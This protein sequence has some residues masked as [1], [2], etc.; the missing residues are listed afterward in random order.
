VHRIRDSILH[1]RNGYIFELGGKSFFAFGG[2]RSH[3]IS[4]GILDE[5]DYPSR[6]R[7]ME[8]RRRWT[9]RQ[10]LFRVNHESWWQEEMPSAEEM[11]FGLATLQAHGNRVDYIVSHCCPQGISDVLSG[12]FY[13]PDA[14]TEYFE[15]LSQTV[16]FDY[17]F[18][19]HYHENR[20][21]FRKYI[22][23]Y[24]QIIELE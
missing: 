13:Q 21:F 2:A 11:A 10:K 18:F 22:L 16:D 9:K 3:D 1:L 5:A 4:D 7:F 17:W 24:E 14:L 6:E 19:G 8:V 12:G 23:L 15:R 20:S